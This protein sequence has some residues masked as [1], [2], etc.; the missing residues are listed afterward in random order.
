[1]ITETV[2]Q[3]VISPGL[4]SGIRWCSYF[5]HTHNITTMSVVL[6]Y[7]H[8][9]STHPIYYRFLKETW[10]EWICFHTYTLASSRSLKIYFTYGTLI[11]WTTAFLPVFFYLR[12]FLASPR[13]IAI[14]IK[15]I[16]DLLSLRWS[17]DKNKNKLLENYRC[18]F[19]V[20]GF[21]K[22]SPCFM[23]NMGL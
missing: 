21:H 12:F 19:P 18:I 8:T 22:W 13:Y 1:M 17:E 10:T 23:D 15:I 7:Q 6:V 9:F 14:E 20:A 11:H 5:S 4:P 2:T 3:S 16:S